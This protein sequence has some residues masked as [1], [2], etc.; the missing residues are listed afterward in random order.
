MPRT[1]SMPLRERVRSM[2]GL[3]KLILLFS[4]AIGGIY[5]GVMSPTEAAA[6]AALVAILIAFA[7]RT[8]TW[9][10]LGDALLETIWTT[11]MLFFIV[12]GA[13]MFAYFMALTRLPNSL[14]DW[15]QHLQMSPLMVIMM[16]IAF[17][18]VLGCFLDAISMILITIP[19]FLPLAQGLGFD[20]VWFGIVVLVVVEVGMITP[21]VGLNIFVIRAQLP[22]V[23]LADVYWG[24]VPFLLAAGGI[25]ALLLMFHDL[26][27]WLPRLLYG[28]N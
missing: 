5:S 26:A 7:T 6:V 17:Y 13:F 24:I 27:L 3:W 23:K 18:L 12:I 20:P 11:G 15:V 19:V 2:S 4:I 1:P 16:M 8:M 10:A 9:K 22:D 25:V 28:D 21:P 14:T